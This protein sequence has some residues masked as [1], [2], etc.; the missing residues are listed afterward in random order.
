MST[1]LQHRTS[2]NRYVLLVDGREAGFADYRLTG[3]AIV[4]THT[5]VDPAHRDEGLASTL[6]AGA[7]DDVRTGSGLKLVAQCPF[8]VD[9]IDAHAE[10]HELEERG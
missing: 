6:I 4:F 10:Y 9:F 8:V 7:L 3:N 2:Q 5:E 1:E